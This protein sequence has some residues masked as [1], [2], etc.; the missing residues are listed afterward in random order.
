VVRAALLI[1]AVLLGLALAREW[2]DVSDSFDE[3]TVLGVVLSGLVTVLAVGTTVLAWRAL[4]VGLGAYLPLR[5]AIRVFF[6]GQ[7]GKYIPGSVWPVLAQMELS[8]DYGVGRA[9]SASASLVVLA[10][11]VPSGGVVASAT[12]PF[13]STSA[14]G[15]YWWALLAIPVFLVVLHPAVLGRLLALAARLLKRPGVTQ[16]LGMRHV[17]A[18]AGW[19]M[20][21]FLLYGLAA[22]LVARDLHPSAGDGRLV[23]LAI[24]AYALAWTAGFLIIVLPAGAGVREAVL[25]LALSPAL[26]KGPALLVAVVARLLATI[27]D[28]VWAAI[29]FSLR[30]RTPLGTDGG[31]Q[32]DTGLPGGGQAGGGQAGGG[33]AGGGQAGGGLAGGGQAGVGVGRHGAPDAPEAAAGAAAAHG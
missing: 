7:I 2:H 1:A 18:A 30:P 26:P 10:L 33:Q 6:V 11:A 15:H 31:G 4:L 9:E 20:L 19:L 8:R 3:L 22:W 5:A 29:G 12:L 24:G 13:V 14:L 25:V 32:A 16:P 28:L 17:L 23:L 21:G 27:A